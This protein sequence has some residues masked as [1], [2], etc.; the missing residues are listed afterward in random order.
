MEA[1]NK[2][3]PLKHVYRSQLIERLKDAGIKE[4]SEEVTVG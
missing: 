4:S 1:Q 3:I 2:P